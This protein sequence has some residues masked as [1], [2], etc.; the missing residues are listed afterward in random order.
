MKQFNPSLRL[1][2]TALACAAA[3]IPFWARASNYYA[4]L[5]LAGVEATQSSRPVTIAL[6]GVTPPPA[7]VG[8]PYSFDL[9][10]P[11][12]LEGP[13]GTDPANVTWSV[14]SG[15]LPA[16]L[17]LSGN[18]ISGT[19]TGVSTPATVKLRAEYAFGYQS[20][21][22]MQ[23]YAFEVHPTG[24]MDFGAY[25]AWADGTYAQSCE[26]YIRPKDANHVYT[27]ATGDGVYRTFRRPVR[28]PSMRTA[29][30]AQTGAVGLAWRFSTNPLQLLGPG[31]HRA[32][33]TP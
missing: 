6:S 18:A 8:V 30:R 24:I 20:V 26:G 13:E 2:A 28:P 16:S 14:F 32:L 31:Q 9:R 12:S 23:E 33:H 7:Y 22:A 3:F 15:T 11:V 25:R 29:I 1:A 17:V 10:A 27:D 4:V 21:G 5:P 19:P